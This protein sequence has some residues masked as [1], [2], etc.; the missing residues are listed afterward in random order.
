M[1]SGGN[2]F[3]HFSKS[4][5]FMH[6]K[7]YRHLT[8]YIVLLVNFLEFSVSGFIHKD[9]KIALRVVSLG[10]TPR[11]GKNLLSNNKFT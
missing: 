2:D 10:S 11:Q 9:S 7:Q 5:D 8:V 6:F 3:N 4:T 1:K